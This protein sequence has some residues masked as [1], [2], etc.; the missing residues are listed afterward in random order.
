MGNRD[1]G[2]LASHQTLTLPG[3]S[4]IGLLPAPLQVW[5]RWDRGLWCPTQS[6]FSLSPAKGGAGVQVWTT[7]LSE[8]SAGWHPWRTPI[9]PCCPWE[10][11]GKAS[12][13][14]APAPAP[15]LEA[16]PLA[17]EWLLRKQRRELG[18]VQG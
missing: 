2:A 1:V 17:P 14:Q 9:S 12:W 3:I 5:E 11:L 18:L 16:G 6:G 8:R 10:E 13:V 4:S 15:L 7:P